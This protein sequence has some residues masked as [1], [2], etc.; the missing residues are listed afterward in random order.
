MSALTIYIDE[1][2]D[3]GVRDGLAF[4]LGRHEWMCVAAV[5]VRSSRADEVVGWVK[6]LRDAAKSTQAGALH[7]HRINRDRR[8]RV[9]RVLAAKPCRA[10]VMVSHKSN[11]REYINPRLGQMISSG[12]FYNW[13]LRLL[14]ERVTAWAET[15][16]LE[17]GGKRGPI[18]IVFAS[19]GHD[20]EHFFKYV[21]KLSM[22]KKTGT[23]YL[24]GP[25]LA[26]ELLDRSNWTVEQA[27]ENAGL[28][29]ADVVASAFYQSVNVA[30][31]VHDIEPA[32]TLRPIISTRDGIAA[33]VGVTL[34][35]LPAQATVPEE[36]RPIFE[37]YG[38]L[39]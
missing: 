22:Q 20:W 31:P 34:F 36:S 35:P 30:S 12:H 5:C 15:W 39:F 38:Y 21:D 14:L 23:L 4:R 27:A 2:G 10:F 9:C 29:L 1:A 28:Q 7:Y 11:L 26:S 19:R 32:T 16:Q 13:C 6:E 25:G 37:R 24:K 17:N 3:P 18:T 33:N 8:Q